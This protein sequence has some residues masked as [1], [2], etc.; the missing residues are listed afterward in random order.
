MATIIK[1]CQ[2]VLN[3][4]VH[5]ATGEQP[6]FLMFNRRAPRRIGV[7]LPQ[8][9]QDSDLEVALEVVRRTNLEQARKWRDRANVGRQ[10]QRVEVDQLVWIKKDCTTS[11]SERKLG[12][13]WVGPYKVKEIIRNGGAYRLE[14]LFDGVRIQRA[15]DKVKPYVGQGGILVHPQEVFVQKDTEEEVPKPARE[16][17]PPKRYIEEDEIEEE[18]GVQRLPVGIDPEPVH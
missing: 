5:E 17:R 4:V 3:S 2:R 10:N 11:L 1:K 8:L 13:K 14:N 6:H 15:A 9:Q 12:V 16:R 7:E 18:L